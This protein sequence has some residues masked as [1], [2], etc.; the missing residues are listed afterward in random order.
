MDGE[1]LVEGEAH[2]AAALSCIGPARSESSLAPESR[3]GIHMMQELLVN[4]LVPRTT[5]AASFQSSAQ[6]GGK[7][8][9]TCASDSSA[10]VDRTEKRAQEG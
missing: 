10:T 7:K 4:N 3:N 5:D 1:A 9:E 2:L 8:S 6:R